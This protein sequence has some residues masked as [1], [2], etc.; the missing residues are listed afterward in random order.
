MPGVLFLEIDGLARPILEKALAEG[1]MP[2]LHRWLESGS[3]TLSS[4]ETDTS[5]QTSAS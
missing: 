2:T 5:S 4:W 3:H 1:H